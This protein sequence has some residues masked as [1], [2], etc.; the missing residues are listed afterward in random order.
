VSVGSAHVVPGLTFEGSG[1]DTADAVL[2]GEDVPGCLGRRIQLVQR[3]RVGMSSDLENAVARG[4]DDPLPRSLVL[5]PELVDDLGSRRGP[6]PEHSAARLVGERIDDLERKSVRVRRKG[7][8][9][10]HSHQ[11]PVAC[12][13]VLPLRAFEKPSGD[14]GGSRL[15][16]TA[17][18][19]LDVPE[20]ERLEV[21]EVEPADRLRD[22]SQRVRAGV[23]VVGRIRQLSC[24]DG[25]EDDDARP[26]HGAI[27][28]SRWKP[29]SDSSAW[30]CS[31]WR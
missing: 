27:L 18:E 8:G 17:F 5:L 7:L 28:G 13:R 29:P 22:V 2:A 16:R 23:A 9:G 14:R 19:R 10:D 24:P 3:N 30:F 6:V 20:A 15:R 21:R 1:D 26:A 4:V 11:L 12:R 25:V 31:S